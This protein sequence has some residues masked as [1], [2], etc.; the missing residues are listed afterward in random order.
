MG[1]HEIG[2]V[3]EFDG[4]RL[5]VLS[6]KEKYCADCALRD[7]GLCWKMACC[8]GQRRD[9][10]NV[11]FVETTEP[12]TKANH[13]VEANEMADITNADYIRLKAQ[14][15]ILKEVETV[16]A[17]QTIDSIIRQL[18]A[19]VKEMEKGGQYVRRDF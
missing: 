4:L 10:R 13:S 18:E 1:Y 3:F 16:Y 2:E 7:S 14:V 19:T 9:R 11:C 15:A 6:S 12:L 17:G 5:K 8:S